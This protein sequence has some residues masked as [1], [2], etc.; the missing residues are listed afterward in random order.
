MDHFRSTVHVG[1]RGIMLVGWGLVGYVTFKGA[2]GD[3]RGT[4]GHVLGADN[5]AAR[6]EG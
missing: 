6:M 5:V 3:F 1:V 2:S 4:E